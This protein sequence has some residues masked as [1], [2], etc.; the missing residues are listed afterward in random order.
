M[1]FNVSSDCT[2]SRIQFP[3]GNW[4]HGVNETSTS[5]AL[6]IATATFD[7]N[8]LGSV[9]GAPNVTL[10]TYFIDNEVFSAQFSNSTSNIIYS[11]PML[12]SGSHTLR[13]TSNNSKTRLAIEGMVFTTELPPAAPVKH[14]GL[15]VGIVLGVT[16]LFLALGLFAFL[17]RKR[18]RQESQQNSTWIVSASILIFNA[19]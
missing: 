19:S 6:G 4:T 11:S 14:T 13:L 8:V 7:F 18:R 16:V 2:D 15:I 1:S 9:T 10:L 3:S 12:P 17:W 5:L